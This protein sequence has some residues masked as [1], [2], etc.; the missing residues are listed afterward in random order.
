M[1]AR[2]F[3]AIIF[4][5][6]L[7]A[8]GAA[9]LIFQ[10]GQQVL[11]KQAIP[12]GHFQPP[13]AQS[14]PDYSQISNWIDHPELRNSPSRWRPTNDSADVGL[15]PAAVFYVHPTTYLKRDRWNAPVCDGE[16]CGESGHRAGLFVQSQA[17]AFSD[18]GT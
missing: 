9:F 13:P 16:E 3:L 15:G 1:C 12:Q 4:W 8:V 6:V 14:G 7:L 11:I 10:Y 18:L 2:R 5:L 17:S